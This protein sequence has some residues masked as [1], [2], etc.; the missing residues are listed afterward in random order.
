[1]SKIPNGFQVIEAF[2]S[3]SPKH[4]AVEGDK[5]GL[6]IGTLNKPVKKVMVTLD[7]LETVVD[8]AIEKQV[9]L[10]IAHHPPIFRPLKQVV[11]DRPEGR[12]LEKCI[13]HDIAVYAAHT[14][15]DIAKGGVNDLLAEAL[16]LEETKVL[17]P[18]TSIQLK[19]LAV[20]VPSNDAEAVRTA[21]CDA[22]AGHVG[23]Y[24]D[25]T[26][27]TEGE[28]TFKPSSEA[29]PYIGSKGELERVNEI[30]VE[31][32]FEADQQ[33]KIIRAMLSAHPYEEVAYDI[34]LLENTRDDRG[35]GL[36]GNLSESISESELLSLLKSTFR[37]SLIKHTRFSGRRISKIALCGG[38]GFFL[39][40][41][42]IAAGAQV[43]ITADI[44]Y[45][46]FFDADNKILLA[47]IGHYESEQFTIELLAEFLH[48][49]FPNFAVLK[50]EINT[51]PVQY[52]S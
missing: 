5:I 28:G 14:N 46:E 38:A 36:V 17:V 19:K 39:L 3:F 37:L 12:I 26:F 32:I 16:G 31:T 11:T 21:I 7:V 4:L 47:D 25:C 34:H 6:Q 15:L 49:K 43:Y 51:N 20:F 48:E 42:A 2:E 1:M 27:S 29:N 41:N 24:S 30:K 9:D 40:P 45:H 50:T 33:N 22:G 44:K 8:E 35:S 52:F 13:K 23:L 10:I 18:T